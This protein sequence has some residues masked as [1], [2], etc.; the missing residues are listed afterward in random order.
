L[1]KIQIKVLKQTRLLLLLLL[2]TTGCSGSLAETMGGSVAEIEDS[3]HNKQ[4]EG[5]TPA[6]TSGD[7]LSVEFL[8]V[9]QG[10]ATL[11]KHKD[12]YL[13]I[14][15]G[16]REYSSFVV[17]YL[18]KQ[19]IKKLDYVIVSHYDA[20]HLNGIVGVLNAI[21]TKQIV[22][23]DYETDTKLYQSY[24]SVVKE[25][26]IPVTFPQ[27]KDEIIWGETSISIVGPIG[28]EYSD[29]NSNSLGIKLVYGDTSFLICGDATSET[30]AD[31]LNAAVDLDSDVFA[32]NHHGSK[33]SN[34]EEF[35]A[36][37]SPESIVISS[38][39]GN[40]YGHP[41]TAI[42]EYGKE[43]DASLY[44]TDLQGTIQAVSD[45]TTIKFQPSA[46][47]DYRSG[48]EL[49]GSEKEPNAA[50]AVPSL[51]TGQEYILNTNTK[52]IHRSDCSSVKEMEK[53]NQASSNETKE[54]LAAQGYN[55]CKICNP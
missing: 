22:A 7:D 17:S 45:G 35:L 46:T 40:S 41:E 42:L 13:L 27:L 34:S 23:A 16:D 14:D 4:N 8:D 31:M 33:Y 18:K 3:D 28:Y 21:P 53:S 47:T 15:G 32:A 43:V 20:D 51:T 30:E 2:L 9:G 5:A 29:S 48:A 38:G 54:V 52:K 6:V 12:A 19:G 49:E 36:A 44:R 24:L 25:K 50:A 39:L 55:P 37:V 11:V 10:S 26:E 1:K